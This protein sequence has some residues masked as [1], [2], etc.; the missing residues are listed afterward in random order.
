M[1]FQESMTILNACTKKVWKL[2]ECAMYYLFVWISSTD[3]DLIHLHPKLC[4]NH[5]G[6]QVLC[7]QN[8]TFEKSTFMFFLAHFKCIC[9]CTFVNQGF[10][11][12]SC[13]CPDLFQKMIVSTSGHCCLST[14]PEKCSTSQVWVVY[15][16]TFHL[17]QRT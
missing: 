4:S 13:W 8:R 3:E 14:A 16:F 5:Q 7:E 11:H 12:W 17:W 1:N 2:I 9:M 10:C 6:H 15:S